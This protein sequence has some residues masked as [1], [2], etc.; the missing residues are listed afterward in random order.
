MHKSHSSCKRV[1]RPYR[2]DGDGLIGPSGELC[3]LADIEDRTWDRTLD[4]VIE[5]LNNLYEYIAALECAS[6]ALLDSIY[7]KRPF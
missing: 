6:N 1:P 2:A 5:E 3:R 7:E 4:V